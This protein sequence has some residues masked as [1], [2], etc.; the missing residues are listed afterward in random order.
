MK[1]NL[2]LRSLLLSGI[3]LADTALAQ[4]RVALEPSESMKLIE[5]EPGFTAHLL[6]HEPQAIDPVEVV[7]DDAGRMWVVEMRDYPFRTSD[8]PRGRIVVLSD[9]DLDGHYETA[10]TY[11]DQLEMPNGLALW[12][13]GVVATV[14]GKLVYLPDADGDLRADS[15]QVWL[16]GFKE[17]NEQL[18]ANHPR[19]GPDGW[20]YIACGLRGGQV[21]LGSDLQASSS[22]PPL[23]IGTRDVRFNLRTKS[24]ELITGPAQFGIAFDAIGHRLFC[25][26][27][28]PATQVMLE[29]ADLEGNPLAGLAPS[30]IDVIASGEASHVFPL[31]DA[32]TTSHL[33]SGQFTAACGVFVRT[34][35]NVRSEV[36]ACEPTGCL[37]RRQVSLR[38]GPRLVPDGASNARFSEEREWLASRDGW[39]RPVNVN[40][41]PDGELVVVDMHRA[42]IEHPRFVPEELKQRPDERWGNEAGRVYWVGSDAAGLVAMIRDLQGNPLSSRSDDDLAVLVVSSN[43]W[44][45]QTASRLLLERAATAMIEPLQRRALES[46]LSMAARCAALRLSANLADLQEGAQGIEIQQPQ[47]T[48]FLMADMSDPSH[49]AVAQV[50]LRIGRDRPQ[51]LKGKEQQVVKLA[52]SASDRG[53]RFEAWLSLG[54]LASTDVSTDAWSATDAEV[55]VAAQSWVQV[56]DRYQLMAMVSA[57]RNEPQLFLLSWLHAVG[58]A[59][60]LPEG[61]LEQVPDIARGLTQATLRDVPPAKMDLHS[62]LKIVSPSVDR[63]ATPGERAAQ[64]AALICVE[65]VLKKGEAKSLLEDDRSWQQLAS[66]CQDEK[67]VTANRIAA[68][69]LLGQSPRGSDAELLAELVQHNSA[70]ELTGPLL[71]AWSAVGGDA[72][73]R[74]LLESLPSASPQVLRIMLPLIVSNPQRLE[75]L[76]DRLEGG[77]IEARQIGAAEL[78]KLVARARGAVQQRLQSQLE[79]ISNSNRAEVIA[80]YKDCLQLDADIARG[81]EVFRKHCAS[82]HRIGQ[83][84]VEV[85]PNISDSRT[86]LPLELLTSILDPNLAID[87]NYFRFIV[88]TDDGRVVEGIIAE[89]TADALVIRGQDDRRERISRDQIA[90][91]KA[92]GVSLMP[93]GV[94]SQIDPQ[95]MADLIAF[96]KGWRY[97]DADIPKR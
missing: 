21:Q 34:M 14:A 45:S 32:W 82:C 17:D 62:L 16:E 40:L 83:V 26:N 90:E 63:E 56:A 12:K 92:T 22:S 94:E 88:S 95:A 42:V 38:D 1:T 60:A 77:Q 28:N 46:E 53:L 93:E 55:Q 91:M 6:A 85:G 73:N 86:K 74:Y 29:Q 66:L 5:L 3:L 18:R 23:E 61:A 54:A 48:P 10:Q 64:L 30:V 69:N 4:R 36:F 24:I 80:K 25:S 50:A 47:L 75:M 9:T 71:T 31:V 89:E 8:Q 27:R 33:H 35:D 2:W 76:A 11:A 67:L 13:Q 20:W 87:N 97:L 43:P 7:F 57:L 70:P 96:V 41:A 81:T 78:T 65:Q 72:P 44:L 37:V 52:T 58:E 19:L 84:G 49:G 79:R 68:I 39:F 59:V 15:I 51:L